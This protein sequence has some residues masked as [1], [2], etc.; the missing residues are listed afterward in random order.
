[1]HRGWLSDY[2]KPRI[3]RAFVRK[4]TKPKLRAT[5]E[6]KQALQQKYAKFEKR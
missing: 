5:P 6:Q 3:A 4:I 2:L 1:M